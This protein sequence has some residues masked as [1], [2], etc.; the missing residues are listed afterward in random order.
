MSLLSSFGI[1]NM[2]V[3]LHKTKFPYHDVLKPFKVLGEY[4]T[5]YSCNYLNN[6]F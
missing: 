4:E 6:Q 3:K 1:S 5:A 2:K